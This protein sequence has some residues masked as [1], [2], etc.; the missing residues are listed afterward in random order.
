[1]I[2]YL[3]DDEIE[4]TSTLSF[5]L[6]NPEKYQILCFNDMV[7]ASKSIASL[8]E[9]EIFLVILDHDFANSSG[10]LRNGYD[11]AQEIKSRSW[12]R[13]VAPVI[14]L[15][16]RESE[17]NFNSKARMLGGN[18][19]DEFLSKTMLSGQ[20]LEIRVDFFTNRLENFLIDKDEYG[21]ERAIEMYT[22]PIPE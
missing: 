8:Q 9:D 20:T 6:E 10:D 17:E 18:A 1:M 15:T 3:V 11:L 2:L 4:I 12:M 5:R 22:D 14:Y 19:P 13:G 16:G 7:S 21:L